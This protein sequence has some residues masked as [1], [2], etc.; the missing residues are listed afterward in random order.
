MA[1]T[2]ARGLQNQEPKGSDVPGFAGSAG[3]P[4]PRSVRVGRLPQ[5][6]TPLARGKGSCWLRR[7][8]AV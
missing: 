2:V 7:V 6:A 1:V 8:R 3:C 5:P 4:T